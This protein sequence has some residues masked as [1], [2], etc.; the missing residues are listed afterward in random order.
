MEKDLCF[1]ST[2]PFGMDQTI[3]HT[4][5]IMDKQGGEAMTLIGLLNTTHTIRNWWI[6]FVMPMMQTYENKENEN[7]GVYRNYVQKWRLLLE[8]LKLSKKKLNGT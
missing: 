3:A 1:L 6:K 5:I 7:F 8:R 2:L 4:L